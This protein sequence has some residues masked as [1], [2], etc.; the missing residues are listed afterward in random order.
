MANVQDAFPVKVTLTPLV[1]E[2]DITK[3]YMLTLDSALS[4]EEY[5]RINSRL[6]EWV[7]SKDPFILVD[8]G[9]KLVRVSDI[10]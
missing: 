4:D 2:I 5:K 8:N 1:Y 3:K 7:N 9:M 6:K 10:E